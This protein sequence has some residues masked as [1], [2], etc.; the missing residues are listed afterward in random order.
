M[1]IRSLESTVANDLLARVSLKIGEWNELE[2]AVAGTSGH[3]AYIPSREVTHLYTI[4]YRLVASFPQGA[5]VLLQLD[6]STAPLPDEVQIFETLVFEP[7]CRWNVE[8]QR[9][10]LFE[11]D[12][13][14]A[15]DDRATLTMTIVFAI[16]FYWHGSIT[17]DGAKNGQRIGLQDG[18]IYFI[19][20]EG[21][22]RYGEELIAGFERDPLSLSPSI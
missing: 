9:T 1:R 7:G 18:T 21:A 4:A 22:V 10:F 20:D 16:A 17:F 15:S 11:R 6:N 19:G 5:W 2:D 3:V 13:H 8:S 12:S 14:G